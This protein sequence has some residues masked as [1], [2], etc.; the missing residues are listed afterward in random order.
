MNKK[1]VGVACETP[2]EEEKR[3]QVYITI[4]LS[5]SQPIPFT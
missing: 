5:A 1:D 4:S 3:N 2:E